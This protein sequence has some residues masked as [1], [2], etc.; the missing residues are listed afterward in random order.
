MDDN[1]GILMVLSLLLSPGVATLFGVLLGKLIRYIIKSKKDKNDTKP[2]PTT[3][4]PKI[5]RKTVPKPE[6]DFF[7]DGS[8]T[9]LDDD[10][11]QKLISAQ[12]L[13]NTKAINGNINEEHEEETISDFDFNKETRVLKV[14][15]K[16]TTYYRT[17]VKYVQENYQRHPI[18]SGL[19]TRSKTFKKT[20]KL[21]NENLENLH[22]EFEQGEAYDRL[23]LYFQIIC[24]LNSPELTPKFFKFRAL[25]NQLSLANDYLNQEIYRVK[26]ILNITTR[27]YKNK[28]PSLEEQ[29]SKVE[30]KLNKLSKKKPSSK[31]ETLISENNRILD[32]LNSNLE[33]LKNELETLSANYNEEIQSLENQIVQNQRK[34]YAILGKIK[35]LEATI[36]NNA[37]FSP[38]KSLI[39]ISYEKI[40]G[41]YVIRNVEKE[42]YYVGQSKDVLRRLKQHFK[43]TIPNNPI[44]AEDYYTSTFENKENLF[45]FRII[46]LETKD[47]LDRTEKELIE[48]YDAFVS[49]YNGTHGNE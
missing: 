3:H 20:Y 43:G 47:E 1:V 25:G 36:S 32:D 48:Q 30:K 7:K 11:I 21:S 44:F 41:C 8:N 35:P 39:G 14:E 42:K 5:I 24:K 45:E 29:I 17:I 6:I 18:Y 33:N 46:Q 23:P 10:Y 49:G 2:K 4:E 40:V 28:F 26:D 16:I 37:E 13:I 31:V 38:L 9:V 34:E 27:Q 19:K 15:F 22:E 12:S